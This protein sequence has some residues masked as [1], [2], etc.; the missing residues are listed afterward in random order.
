MKKYILP[1]IIVG[2][3][4]T[5]YVLYSRLI[6]KNLV[7]TKKEPIDL[8]STLIK[9]N[10]TTYSVSWTKTKNA[11]SGYDIYV[12]TNN[13]TKRYI[14]NSG[15]SEYT[16]YSWDVIESVTVRPRTIGIESLN[17]ININIIP[18]NNIS[19]EE[20]RLD[21]NKTN[22]YLNNGIIINT[23]Q[24]VQDFIQSSD[25]DCD[26]NQPPIRFVKYNLYEG[27]Q[28]QS[29]PVKNFINQKASFR[30]EY[31][32]NLESNKFQF[33]DSIKSKLNLSNSYYLIIIER[34]CCNGVTPPSL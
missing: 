26:I 6:L 3:I 4:F 22:C 28:A 33:H 34:S 19:F 14:Q 11:Q 2:L 18:L 25:I 12:L 9:I 23:P 5:G 32:R 10:D 27:D 8:T 16:F 17:A 13:S 1:S 24:E 29:N 30:N 31:M 21:M 15:I 20:A 7:E